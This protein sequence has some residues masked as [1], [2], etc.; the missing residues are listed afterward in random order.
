ML[1]LKNFSCGYDKIDIIKNITFKAKR[2]EILCIVGP[3]GCGKSTLLKAIGRL[4]EYKG[5]LTF[6]SKDTKNLP[7][8][9]FAKHIALMT[10]SNTVY[11]PYTVYET[12]A[13][14][15]YAYLKGALSSLSKEDNLII[16]EAIKSVGLI[17]L[18]DKL[19]SE[20][21][22]G[23][24][25]RVFIAKAFAQDPEII[26][27]DEPTNHLDLKYQIEILE[28]LSLWAK[29]NNKIVIAVLHDLNL[30]NLFGE[31]II[32]LSHG[33]I[34]SQGTPKEVFLEENLKNVY[35]IDVKNFML[36]A[37]KQWQ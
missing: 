14:G 19:I 24:L 23:Q 36:N 20:L 26:L 37:L 25:Q 13:L 33:E 12:V 15:R 22:G 17:D 10:Q 5:T 1:E 9:E 21:S 7:V 29:E 8:K 16:T 27:L 31:K 6:D 28:Y 32:L 35:N 18:K 11:F 30:S 4:I 34:V 3:N 2:G